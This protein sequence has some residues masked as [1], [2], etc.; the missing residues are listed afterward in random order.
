MLA[1]KQHYVRYASFVF[2][3]GVSRP[4]VNRGEHVFSPETEPGRFF[5]P[6]T[7]RA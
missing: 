7:A 1:S 6:Y 2:S 4:L 3:G 5:A